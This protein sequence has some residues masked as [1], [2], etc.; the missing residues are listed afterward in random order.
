MKFNELGRSFFRKMVQIHSNFVTTGTTRGTRGAKLQENATFSRSLEKSLDKVV[1]REEKNFSVHKKY[2]NFFQYRKTA[3]YKLSAGRSMVE[4]LGVLA[5]IGVLSVG[6][7]SGYSKAMFKY[8]LNKQAEQISTIFNNMLVEHD[9]LKRSFTSPQYQN[10]ITS[11]ILA[12]NIVSPEM[13]NAQHTKVIDIFNN[14]Y[15][16]SYGTDGVKRI[17]Y[18]IVFNNVQDYAFTE[19]CISVY[20]ILKEFSSYLWFIQLSSTPRIYGD[21][22]CERYTTPEYCLKNQKLTDFEKTC[23]TMHNSGIQRSILSINWTL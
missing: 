21:A 4:M 20:N 19:Q 5:I 9:K 15:R 11:T 7:L 23:S 3:L 17:N 2:M 12:M 1:S 10:D 8:K 22:F 6:A 14:E 16:I 18:S 13:L